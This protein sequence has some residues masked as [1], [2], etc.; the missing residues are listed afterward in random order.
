MAFKLGWLVPPLIEATAASATSTPASLA[1]RML[2]ALRPLVSCVW[3]CTGRAMRTFIFPSYREPG[4]T[5]VHEAMAYGLPMIVSDT[6]GPG[7]AVDDSSG[8]R[9]H[10]ETPEQYAAD[11]AAAVARLVENP[12]ERIALGAGAAPGRGNRAM[13]Q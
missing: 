5:V 6:G 8:I 4:G 2:A 12:A 7:S 11:L 13:G 1:I 9:V 3:K 10:P